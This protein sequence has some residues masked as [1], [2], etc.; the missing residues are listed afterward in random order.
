MKSIV[1]TGLLALAALSGALAQDSNTWPMQVRLA[2]AG[3]LGMTISW[4]TFSPLSNPT[5]K[6]GLDPHSLDQTVSSNISITY[7][8]SLTWNNH[9]GL[10]GLRADTVYWYQPQPCNSSSP[11][12]SFKTSRP[13][14][15]NTPYSVAIAVDLGLMG[16]DGLT[17]HVGNGAANPLGPNDLNTIQSLVQNNGTYDFLAHGA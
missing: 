8:T 4:N 11:V 13:A 10:Q 3:P 15:D 12:Y 1:G 14:G 17:T 5:V 9:V 2:Y 7:P 6:Y 16:P